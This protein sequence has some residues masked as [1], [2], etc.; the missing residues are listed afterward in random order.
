MLVEVDL[1]ND[2]GLLIPGMYGEATLTL[3]ET[4]NALVLTAT[5]IHHDETGKSSVCV[6]EN[7]VVRIVPVVTGY[8]DGRQVQIV[9]GVDE[10]SRI[11]AGRVGRLKEGQKV[12]VEGS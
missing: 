5:A 1:L 3:Q 2:E 9:S 8:D 12:N 10:T 6:V 4:P 11:T 7:G